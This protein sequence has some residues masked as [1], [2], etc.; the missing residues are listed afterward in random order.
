MG[1]AGGPPVWV[2]LSAGLV[3]SVAASM[4][5]KRGTSDYIDKNY[6]DKWDAWELQQD[7]EKT[8]KGS[9]DLLDLMPTASDAEVRERYLHLCQE[10]HPDKGGENEKFVKSNL[11]YEYIR[12]CRLEQANEMPPESP[13]AEQMTV[14]DLRME[15][16]AYGV[17][18]KGCVEKAD[19]V[20]LLEQARD[21]V[22][23]NPGSSAPS[24]VKEGETSSVEKTP[25]KKASAG[26]KKTAE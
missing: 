24:P 25:D 17:S 23:S 1:V 16:D 20:K 6:K 3:F 13:D 22:V 21:D 9:Y 18:H 2:A 12:A 14:K 10:Y 15:L 7:R 11:A 5:A 26:T 8:L 19:L 4:L